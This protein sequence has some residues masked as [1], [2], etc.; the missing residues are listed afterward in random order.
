MFVKVNDTHGEEYIINT[1]QITKTYTIPRSY[2][3]YLVC[4]SD[5][6]VSL[7]EGSYRKLLCCLGIIK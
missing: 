3:G 4:Q 6:A 5:E 7:D 2:G 1:D